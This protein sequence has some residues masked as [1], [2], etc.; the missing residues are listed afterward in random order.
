MAERM[1]KISTWPGEKS[2]RPAVSDRP[3]SLLAFDFCLLPAPYF[4]AIIPG[5]FP[6]GF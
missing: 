2:K 1:A 5:I 3:F 4:P 6:A